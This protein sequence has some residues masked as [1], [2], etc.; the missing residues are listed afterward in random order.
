MTEKDYYK[1]LG[2]AKDADNKKIKEAYRTLALKYHPDHNQDDPQAINQMKT[3]NEAYAVLSDAGKRR[4]YDSLRQQFGSNAY[5]QF[6]QS[7][8]DQDIFNNSDINQ[9][10]EEMAK[11]FGLKGFEDTFGRHYG[12]K[13]HNFE[14]KRPGFYGKGFIYRGGLGRKKGRLRQPG[15]QRPLNKL[16][17]HMLHKLSGLTLPEKGIDFKD[18][19]TISQQQ[20]QTGTPYAYYLKKKAK[21]L[22]VKIP[23]GVKAN[24][25]IRLAGMGKEGK[26]GG[27]AGDLYLKVKIKK[28]LIQTIR[29]SISHWTR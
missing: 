23:P 21:K 27:S 17:R 12:D 22:I 2:I 15:G 24:Q 18:I 11:L 13:F 16:A 25:L 7:Y 26:A 4:E 10:F 1:I 5:S 19:I 8:T 29:D 20:A 3:I 28:P 6:R 14:F 9:I